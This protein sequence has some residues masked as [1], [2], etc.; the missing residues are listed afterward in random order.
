MTTIIKIALAA[1]LLTAGV[2]AGRAALKHYTFEDAVQESLLFS[3]SRTEAELADRVVEIA[4]EYAIPLDPDD[5]TV[6]REPFLIEVSAPYTDTVDLLPGLYS[7][8]WDFE[9]SVSARLLEDTRPRGTA[10]RG[11]R[12]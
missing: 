7:L 12:R 2:Q 3:S 4:A 10:P 1:V 9:T 8:P 6:R 5:L 11:K